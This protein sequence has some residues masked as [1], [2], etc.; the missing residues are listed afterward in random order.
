MVLDPLFTTRLYGRLMQWA[1]RLRLPLLPS[2][3]PNE[4]AAAL[5]A[6]VPEGKTAIQ[7]ITDLYVEDLY[8]PR[9][10]NQNKSEQALLAWN[11]LQPLL[12]RS[13]LRARLSG[14][15]K[16]RLIFKRSPEPPPQ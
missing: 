7:S 10:P 5:V 14:L 1:Q 11:A 13:W 2:H 3:T 15:A 12:R 4:Q 9:E 6:A 16:V 8:S